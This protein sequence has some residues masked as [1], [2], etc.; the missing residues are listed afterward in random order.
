MGHI[1]CDLV[2]QELYLVRAAVF[3]DRDGTLMLD[4]GFVGD[5]K[6]VVLLPTVVVG[7]RA[8]TEAGVRAHRGEQPVGRLARIFR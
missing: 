7:L 6:D 3:L 2:E 1:I 4:K 5:P 8:L